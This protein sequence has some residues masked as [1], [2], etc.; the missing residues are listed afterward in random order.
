MRSAPSSS[1]FARSHAPQSAVGIAR[2]QAEIGSESSRE[3]SGESLAAHQL[4]FTDPDR[5]DRAR[6]WAESCARVFATTVDEARANV[7]LE[8]RSKSQAFADARRKYE[9]LRVEYFAKRSTWG[10]A[11][12][13]EGHWQTFGPAKAFTALFKEFFP[14][15]GGA[16]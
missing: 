3:G 4:A 9:S 12:A 15:E 10:T 6:L 7:R 5:S 2:P 8:R 11:E 14:R 13:T 1:R 16:Q